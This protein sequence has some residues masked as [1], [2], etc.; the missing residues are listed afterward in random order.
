MKAFN[1]LLK[2]ISRCKEL[3]IRQHVKTQKDVEESSL[4][5]SKIN[6]YIDS[7]PCLPKGEEGHKILKEAFIS[8]ISVLEPK[9]FCDI[10]ANDGNTSLLAKS[11]SNSC[12]VIGFEANPLIY[13]N[14]IN[15]IKRSDIEWMNLA[16][17]DESG[18]LTIYIPRRL[19]R[20]YLDGKIVA[21]ETS[22]PDNTGKT[23][24]LKR[25]EDATYERVDVK[26]VTLDEFFHK[27]LRTLQSR[28]F[29]LWIDV[30]GAAAKVLSGA[31]KVLDKTL[32]VFIETEGFAFWKDQILCD[33]IVK[34]LRMKGFI[35]IARDREYEE[36]QFNILFIHESG[37]GKISQA[38]SVNKNEFSQWIKGINKS[39]TNTQD[40]IK[41]SSQV[42]VVA[43]FQNQIPVLVPCFNNPTYSRMMIEQLLC[44]GFCKIIIIDNASTL[45]SMQEYLA[46]V[47]MIDEVRV[48]QLEHNLGPR[49][50]FTDERTLSLLPRRFCVTDPDLKFN[51]ALPEGFVADMAIVAEKYKIG[52]VG[53]ALEI[54][55]HHLMDQSDYDIDGNIQK[56][57]DWE[58]QFWIEQ[59]DRLSGGDGVYI[60]PVDSTFALYDQEYF[61]PEDYTH[62]LRIAGRFTATHLPWY[63]NSLPPL[64]ELRFYQKNQLYS[65]YCKD[66]ELPRHNDT[67]V[68]S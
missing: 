43:H 51:S 55:D 36:K 67:S 9:I 21:M 30:E 20:A 2:S 24:L 54:S 28:S 44:L 46:D 17:S 3:G 56:I 22:E 7:I 39:K 68:K 11:S 48:I 38:T 57:W 34:R 23:S 31:D 12:R 59:I 13:E 64:D 40:A 4:L 35:P 65:Y 15:E 18:Q 50:C 10:G 8:F 53:F 16:V 19:S 32:A 33:E 63:P 26:A 5:L 14:N 61:K 58:K 45:P 25:N 6:P 1:I 60:A 27:E 47:K 52:K 29:F 62:A 37:I 49:H 66:K 41:Y 42:S